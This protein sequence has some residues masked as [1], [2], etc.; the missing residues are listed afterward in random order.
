MMG[1][2]KCCCYTDDCRCWDG[3]NTRGGGADAED[4]VVSG[5][6]SEDG[7]DENE[8]SPGR[9]LRITYEAARRLELHHIAMA[10]QVSYMLDLC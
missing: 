7:S 9:A 2:Y 1:G 3:N 6:D 10:P 5:Y 8:D 4:R